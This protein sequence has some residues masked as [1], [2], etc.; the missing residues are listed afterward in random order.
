MRFRPSIL[1]AKHMLA[2]RRLRYLKSIRAHFSIPNPADV[3][4]LRTK[5]G[6]GS[7]FDLGVH[8]IDLLHFITGQR[9][10]SVYAQ[11][12]CDWTHDGVDVDRTVS[13]LCRLE[14]GA[15]AEF[16]CSLEQPFYSG[17]EV[18]GSDSRY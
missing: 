13:A 14:S 2:Q 15:Q 8:L 16:T 10:V 4:N 5:P 6:N 11:A 9:I 18:V 7:L 12:N 17:F 3:M 1:K